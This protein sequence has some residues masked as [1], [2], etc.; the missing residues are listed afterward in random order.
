MYEYRDEQFV[1]S[2]AQAWAA[3]PVRPRWQLVARF[4]ATVLFLPF[5]IV[6]GIAVFC[7]TLAFGLLTEV[8]AAVSSSYEKGFERFMDRAFGRITTLPRWCVLWSE[9]RYEG[10][11]GHYRAEVDKL[12]ARWTARA[13]APRKPKKPLPPA[14]CEI[15]RRAYRG[16]GG[17]YVVRAAA[18]QGWELRPS[19]PEKSIRLW[20]SAASASGETAHSA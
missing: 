4:V 3:W 5:W 12:L 19:D 13:S 15:P 1:A 2:S 11:A 18:A 16:V 20:W 8:V 10:D 17:D 9:M 6:F 14:E 7:A